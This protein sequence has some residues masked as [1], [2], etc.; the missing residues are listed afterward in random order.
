MSFINYYECLDSDSPNNELP[1]AD[2]DSDS[3]SDY[4]FDNDD[5]SGSPNNE[6]FSVDE[7]D[8]SSSDYCFD[9]DDSSYSWLDETW[10]KCE[11]ME[12]EQKFLNFIENGGN[13]NFDI[14][15]GHKNLQEFIEED[16]YLRMNNEYVSVLDVILKSDNWLTV[17]YLV[18]EKNMD[19]IIFL[20]SH[21]NVLNYVI[22]RITRNPQKY[23]SEMHK[24]LIEKGLIV[25]YLKHE[26]SIYTYMSVDEINILLQNSIP[27]EIPDKDGL[28]PFEYRCINFDDDDCKETG[29]LF[30][31][32][33]EKNI[34]GS[35][36]L[37]SKLKKI[38]GDFSS[39]RKIGISNK[40]IAKEI[41]N[42]KISFLKDYGIS[43]DSL[44]FYLS[45]QIFYEYET[46][47]VFDECVEIFN[48]NNVEEMNDLLKEAKKFA[49]K[50]SPIHRNFEKI[51]K[52]LI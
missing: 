33:K 21:K 34:C 50:S 38:A 52:Q 36:I 28:T 19:P 16:D 48:K 7:D 24:L 29:L 18:E 25:D 27:N 42:I 37:N 5:S 40:K 13:P 12:C 6:L 35:K 26:R 31:V 44:T 23:C 47:Y 32:M 11:R 15:E 43:C 49:E 10:H 14:F 17:K 9:D 51:I 41:K 45:V 2:D 1:P 20:P 22:S 46:R 4:C 3:S 39:Y 30:L 8:D